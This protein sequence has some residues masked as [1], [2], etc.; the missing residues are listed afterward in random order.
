M[1]TSASNE[2]K[3]L[4]IENSLPQPNPIQT[5]SQNEISELKKRANV[6]QGEGI[7]R[8]KIDTNAECDLRCL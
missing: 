6:R 5:P 7:C 4:R 8:R 1:V 2:F 3:R